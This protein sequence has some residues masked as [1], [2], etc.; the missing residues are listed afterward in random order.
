VSEKQIRLYEELAGGGVGLIVTGIAYVHS[1][2]QFSPFQNSI[3]DDGCTPG[4][5]RLTTVDSRS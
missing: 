4:L 1:S 3:A 2:G 5:K